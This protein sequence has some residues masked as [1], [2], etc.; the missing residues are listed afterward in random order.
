[1]L[2]ER[3]GELVK[4]E[5]LKKKLWPADTFVDFEH[6][7]NGA[8]KRLR[9][10]LNDSADVPRYIETFVGRGYRFIPPVNSVSAADS[11]ATAEAAPQAAS[12]LPS[13]ASRLRLW[14]AA[15]AFI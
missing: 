12:P 3:P 15:S 14:I 4:R 6:S 10:E 1:M 5:D 7:L 9:S 11:P 2:L 8:V 13:P